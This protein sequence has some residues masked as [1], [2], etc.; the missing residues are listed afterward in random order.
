MHHATVK[1][2]CFFLPCLF[3]KY[4][5]RMNTV[6]DRLVGLGQSRSPGI[7]PTVTNFV[8]VCRLQSSLFARCEVGAACRRQIEWS[9]L[10]SANKFIIYALYCVHV[11]L[12]GDAKKFDAIRGMLMLLVSSSIRCSARK[13]F[14]AMRP[15]ICRGQRGVARRGA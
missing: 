10:C 2:L 6:Y 13:V 15:P 11:S 12:I 8:R 7:E 9:I 4:E 5:I 14:D 1:F 3:S